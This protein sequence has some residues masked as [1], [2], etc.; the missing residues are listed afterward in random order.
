[1]WVSNP[2]PPDMRLL[3]YR[4]L[5][6]TVNL[7]DELV[8]TKTQLIGL[9]WGLEQRQKNLLLLQTYIFNIFAVC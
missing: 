5:A 8:S 3:A 6:H 2:N 9:K 7:K 4:G 1:M